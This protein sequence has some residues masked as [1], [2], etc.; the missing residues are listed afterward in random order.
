MPTRHPTTPSSVAETLFTP[1]SADSW[2]GYP[3]AR[4]ND[5]VLIGTTLLDTYLVDRA[6]GE[7]GMGRIYEAHHSRIPAKRFAIKVLRPELVPSPHIRARF[8]R[9]VEAVARVN[10]PG[11]LG[12]VDVGT[13]PLGWPYMVCEHLSGLDL[14]AYLR[15]FGALKNDRVVHM[16]R[17][18]AEALESTHAQGVIH[19]DVKPSNV[20][21][22]GAFAPLGPEWDDV[23]LIDFGLSRFVGRDDQ[24]TKTGLVM[25]TPAYMSP[26]QAG[27]GRTD[28]L[29]DIYGVGAVL[30]AAATGGPPFREQTQQQTLLAVMNKDPVRPRE[31][32][33]SI[34]EGLELVIQRAMAKQPQERYR[35]M[36]ALCAALASLD[37]QASAFAPSGRPHAGETRGVRLRFVGLA[38]AA[39]LLVAGAIASTLVGLD[40]VA[41]ERLERLASGVPF[42]A[43]LGLALLLL[44]LVRRFALRSWKNTAKLASWLPRLRAPIVAAG[45]AYGAASFALRF[46]DEVIARY[47]FKDVLGRA[48]GVAWPGWSALLPLLGLLAAFATGVHQALS[49]PMRP[50]RR[51]LL[52]PAL[53]TGVVLASLLIVHW[54]LSWRSA[55]SVALV[56]SHD[57]AALS[58]A[59]GANASL[60]QGWTQAPRAH[61]GLADA[62]VAPAV[63]DAGVRDAALAPVSSESPVTIEPTAGPREEPQRAE[64]LHAEPLHAPASAPAGLLAPPGALTTAIAQGTSGLENLSRTYRSDPEVLKA[65]A[66]AYASRSSELT[67]AVQTIEQLLSVS[68]ASA[69]DRDLR[70]ILSKAASVEG[71]ASRAAFSVMSRSMGSAGPDLLYELM[72]KKPGLA[73]RAKF[74]LTRFSVQEKFAPE[75]SIAYDLRFAPSCGSRVALLERAKAVGDQRSINELS[76][77][78]SKPT[79]CGRRGHPPCLARCERHAATISQ[80]IDTIAQRL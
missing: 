16:G 55:G 28:H 80:A 8:D 74:R 21:L 10:H 39:L 31:R 72:L 70:N 54:G 33:A 7:G 29:T 46:G 3:V 40:A 42:T 37:N 34:S 71:K 30:Y 38:C 52:G 64:P 68:P 59:A 69:H 26:E 76:A 62:A 4:P 47:A 79:K 27:G 75:L 63:A 48:P 49:R 32:R 44:F 11:V 61:L 60:A 18:L 73:D 53:T 57:T 77:V 24:L 19:R 14:L 23:K 25:G 41:G 56:Q 20:F 43:L 66:L 51:W 58:D 5:D 65:L 67:E 13:T 45:V 2:S 15:R 1:E 36:S 17:R 12:I 22:M 78:I 50:L 6:L 35:D 9:E